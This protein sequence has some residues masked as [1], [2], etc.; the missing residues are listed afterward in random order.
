M[1]LRHP[2]HAPCTTPIV[3]T[4][5]GN[6]HQ[7]LEISSPRNE[8]MTSESVEARIAHIQ[9]EEGRLAWAGEGAGEG[10]GAYGGGKR[11]RGGC[12]QEMQNRGVR[13]PG[14]LQ[15]LQGQAAQV[16]QNTM[17]ADRLFEIQQI[18]LPLRQRAS[19]GTNSCASPVGLLR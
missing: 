7:C 9:N 16:R 15:W 3:L 17:R 10:M 14:L 12:W 11:E 5:L 1:H 6:F 4:T 13:D 8:P 2:L 18:P 19:F